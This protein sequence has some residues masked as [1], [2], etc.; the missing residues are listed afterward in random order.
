MNTTLANDVTT[1]V[2]GSKPL[3]WGAGVLEVEKVKTTGLCES[4]IQRQR[5]VHL[6]ISLSLDCCCTSIGLE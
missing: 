6:L 4:C 5:Q 2:G 1:D 3:S